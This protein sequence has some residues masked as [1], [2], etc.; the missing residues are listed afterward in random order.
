MFKLRYTQ[1]TYVLRFWLLVAYVVAMVSLVYGGSIPDTQTM[2]RDN[3]TQQQASTKIGPIQIAVGVIMLVIG[4]L[5][6]FA[7]N[8]LLR[9][10]MFTTG[11]VVLGMGVLLLCIRIR[12]P[13][14]STGLII[15]YLVISIVFGIAGGVL[16]A[17]VWWLGLAGVGALGGIALSTLILSFKDGGLIRSPIG[18]GFFIAGIAVLM[19]LLIFLFERV[20]VILSTAFFGSLAAFVGLDCFIKVGYRFLLYLLLTAKTNRLMYEVNGKIYGMIGGM[21]GMTVLGI[22]IQFYIYKEP[23][24]IREYRFPSWRRNKVS[25]DKV[26]TEP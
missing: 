12:A 17:M 10:I 16:F 15:A 14:S 26:L 6:T 3:G 2:L 11:F 18:R 24:G 25:E 19:I 8:R 9:A 13:G 7:G 4:I 5:F 1:S 23:V 20:I 22:A 21:L